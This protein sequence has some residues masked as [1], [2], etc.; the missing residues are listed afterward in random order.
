MI[1]GSFIA[2]LVLV[3]QVT[4][5][6]N[7]LQHLGAQS[8]YFSAPAQYG[9]SADLPSGCTVDQAA[10]LLRHGSRYPSNG[11]YN[12]WVSLYNKLRNATFTAKGP[13]EFLP[14]WSPPLDDPAQQV[15]MLSGTGTLEAFQLGVQLKFLK[16]TKPGTQL[17]VWAASQQRC[18][19]TAQWFL[20]GYNSAGHYDVPALGRIITM[21]DSVNYTYVS[22]SFN[23]DSHLI[24]T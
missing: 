4:A 15:E 23:L 12:G 11:A 14:T 8:P 17:T 20:Q 24:V 22:L 9:V 7:P 13:L 3:T 6:F 16:L 21:A 1:S 18:V 10:Y 19:D 5:F 2:C